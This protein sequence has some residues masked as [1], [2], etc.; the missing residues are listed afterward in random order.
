M[1]MFPATISSDSSGRTLAARAKGDLN[2]M[3]LEEM[4]MSKTVYDLCIE[5]ELDG[6]TDRQTEALKNRPTEDPTLSSRYSGPE[7]RFCPEGKYIVVWEYFR[8][9][10]L[11]M[12]HKFFPDGTVSS[13]PNF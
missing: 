6:L 5:A 1:S 10:N 7:E 12:I 13:G 11:R 4:K 3:N 8:F 9:R 2:P